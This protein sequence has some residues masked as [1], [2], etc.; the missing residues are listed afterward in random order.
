MV[1]KFQRR[2]SRM[3][4]IWQKHHNMLIGLDR[5]CH[6]K[7]K[8]GLTPTNSSNLGLV[9]KAKVEECIKIHK[10]WRYF[11]ALSRKFFDSVIKLD[12]VGQFWNIMTR[13]LASHG[14]QIVLRLISYDYV[15]L[16]GQKTTWTPDQKCALTLKNQDN[17]VF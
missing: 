8:L 2:R 10:K 11:C 12:L 3:S 9:E 5:E 7:K 4:W 17:T 15:N 16:T 6:T 1:V 14:F 13:V